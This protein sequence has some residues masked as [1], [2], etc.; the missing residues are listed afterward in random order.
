MNRSTKSGK[1]GSIGKS[2]Q[3]KGVVLIHSC[4]PSTWKAEAE[5]MAVS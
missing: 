2:Q 3:A 1:S 4:N 5:R